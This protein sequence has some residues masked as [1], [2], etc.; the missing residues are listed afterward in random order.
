MF[1]KRS[2]VHV[3]NNI[4]DKKKTLCLQIKFNKDKVVH[5]WLSLDSF[6]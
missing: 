6:C 1:K 2:I 4:V 3:C 5:I